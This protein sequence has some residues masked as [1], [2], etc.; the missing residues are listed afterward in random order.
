V[1]GK[2]QTGIW[3]VCGG[4]LT[5]GS[6]N[7]QVPAG[8][9]GV[10]IISLFG[11]NSSPGGSNAGFTLTGYTGTGAAV[12][13]GA[14]NADT[15]DFTMKGIGISMSSAG[16]GAVGIQLNRTQDFYLEN[17]AVAGMVASANVGIQ[18]NGTGSGSYAGNG[19]IV[20]PVIFGGGATNQIG[21]QGTGPSVGSPQGMNAVRIFGGHISLNGASGTSACFDFFAANGNGIF[22]TD[23]ENAANGLT[24]EATQN[25]AILNSFLRIENVTNI[26]NFATG[27]DGNKFSTDNV[28][29]AIINSG[30]GHNQ[31]FQPLQTNIPQTIGSGTSTSNGTAIGAGTS[32]AQPAITITGAIT[33][34]VATCSLNA[35]PVATWQ[36]GIQFL[37][38][39]VTA[40]TV[41]PWLSNPTAGSI[42]PVA[43]VIRCSVSR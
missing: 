16:A 24:I 22:W 5:L 20:E 38:P 2:A 41:T 27:T 21:I 43:A 18:I 13:V 10:S 30:L 14:S 40:N 4:A 34:D 29:G 39:V 9:N 1:L 7:I 12:Q 31:V 28:T 19:A 3:F 36:T 33:T 26:V 37:L 6:F 8:V 35:A 42:T 17:P 23:C 25:P 11:K 32:Q 15:L